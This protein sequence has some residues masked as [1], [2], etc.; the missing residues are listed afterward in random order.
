MNAIRQRQLEDARQLV[1]R[2]GWN[3]SSYQILHPRLRFWFVTRDD[4]PCAVIAYA[5]RHRV[6]MVA[7]AP[8]C[9][10]NDLHQV[11]QLWEKEATKNAETVCYFG[12][13][14]RLKN[15]F[16]SAP[17]SSR[18]ATI[19]LGAQPVWRPCDWSDVVKKHSSL[20][21]QI[22]R[23][24]NKDVIIERYR[25]DHAPSCS[26]DET[27]AT[28]TEDVLDELR[29]A[30]D[31]WL[32]TR[33]LPPL[34]FLVEPQLLPRL[35]DRQI[36]VARFGN[37]VVA[38]LVLT[39]VP[40]RAGWLVE[41]IV[42]R[43]DAP[44]GTTQLLVDSALQASARGGCDYFT[45]GLTPLWQPEEFQRELH[46]H[47]FWL[48]AVWWWLEAHGR[49]FYNFGGLRDFKTRLQP[50]HWEPIYAISNTPH[51]SPRILLAVIG[52]FSDR[53]P[54]PFFMRIF[55]RSLREEWRR[56]ASRHSSS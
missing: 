46:A 40:A 9:H 24:R 12:A 56:Y 37:R 27:C 55:T 53:A 2:H 22:Q 47:P 32:D 4:A 41:Q 31:D 42:R 26:D 33:P 16:D 35:S 38:Y 39:P 13:G 44:N 52:A 48:R 19:L 45:L 5:R 17:F 51:F 25:G 43:S 50:H 7:G 18:Y 11:L 8:I 15:V 14:T 28:L 54:L 6:R 20:R 36:F 49:R 3:A 34:H 21:G 29:G 10:D 23:A 1:L 30:L